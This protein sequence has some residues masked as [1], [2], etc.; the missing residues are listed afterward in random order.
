MTDHA[1]GGKPLKIPRSVLIAIVTRAGETLLIER[2]DVPGFW[3][4]VTGSQDEGE[5][6]KQTAERELFEET[7]FVAAEHGGLVDL[8]YENV[9]CIFPHW[10]RRYPPDATHNRERCFALCLSQPIAPTLAA[11][12]H[13]AFE[14]LPVA[15]AVQRVT[16]WSNAAVFNAV[17]LRSLYAKAKHAA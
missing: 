6:F 3:Q 12:E 7:G 2:A 10:R 1:R 14:W 4:S 9:Y 17:A 11:R 16:S 15:T 5:T 8:H 13:T